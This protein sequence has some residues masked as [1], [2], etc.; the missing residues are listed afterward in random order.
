MPPD[1]QEAH[2]SILSASFVVTVTYHLMLLIIVW[3]PLKRN[4]IVRYPE[5]I[6]LTS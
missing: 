2:F 3:H 1:I 5:R 6:I 4:V